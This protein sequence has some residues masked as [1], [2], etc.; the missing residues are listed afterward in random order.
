MIRAPKRK[1]FVGKTIH[2]VRTTSCN[3]WTFVFTD[4][5]EI[6]ILTE[7]TGVPNLYALAVDDA[8]QR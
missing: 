1:D 4:G 8:A 6:S 7:A 3:M 5:S 2:S